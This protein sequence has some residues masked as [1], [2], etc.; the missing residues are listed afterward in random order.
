MRAFRRGGAT[1]E[2]PTAPYDFLASVGAT[3]W[4]VICFAEDRDLTYP[5]FA[6]LSERQLKTRYR[7]MLVTARP[8]SSV[9]LSMAD[10]RR[11]ALLYYRDIAARI[12]DPEPAGSSA[13]E[14]G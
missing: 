10:E 11:M 6:D 7:L 2:P 3:K 1:V 4:A 5:V 8:P 9:A 12:A 13:R 14:I